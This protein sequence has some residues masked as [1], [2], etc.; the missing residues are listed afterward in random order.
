MHPPPNVGGYEIH[1]EIVSQ[2]AKALLLHALVSDQEIQRERVCVEIAVARDAAKL[3]RR[4]D[5]PIGPVAGVA[6][7]NPGIA[8]G[9]TGPGLTGVKILAVVVGNPGGE[10]DATREIVLDQVASA[11]AGTAVD[12][13]AQEVRG[14]AFDL[15]GPGIEPCCVIG[16]A[17]MAA[18]YFE[19]HHGI[20]GVPVGN[21]FT[22]R[23]VPEVVGFVPGAIEVRASE[24][25]RAHLHAGCFAVVHVVI[26]SC[27]LVIHALGSLGEGVLGSA[28][29]HAAP[30]GIALVARDIYTEQVI[31]LRVLRPEGQRQRGDHPER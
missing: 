4:A 5:L 17:N 20:E 13:R 22:P 28:G 14:P 9:A 3:A 6:A 15:R 30:V 27:I 1:G 26:E 31:R 24:V 10:S 16:S 11:I 18:E 12:H 2:R 25:I 21:D 19:V 7:L 29:V 23:E 8:T